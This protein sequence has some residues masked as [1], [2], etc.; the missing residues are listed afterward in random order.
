LL[1]LSES[2][3]VNFSNTVYLLIQWFPN[4]LSRD[5]LNKNLGKF[6]QFGKGKFWQFEKENLTVRKRK[7]WQFGKGKFDSLKK[8]IST[9]WKRKIW[10]FE[11]ENFDSLKKKILTVWK[12][13]FW[14]FS[15]ILTVFKGLPTL[16]KKRLTTIVCIKENVF[17]CS[18][19]N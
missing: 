16:Q 14:E 1:S 5:T 11:N 6:W 18:Q 7:F 3:L 19:G 2:Y 13:K 17:I 12:V 15:K 10:Q 4:I 9:V 8:K